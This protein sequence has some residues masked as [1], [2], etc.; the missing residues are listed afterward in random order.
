MSRLIAS[1][2]LLVV[3]T[4]GCVAGD[5]APETFGAASEDGELLAAR[6]R[7]AQLARIFQ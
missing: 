5:S 1:A 3:V 4:S 6:D 2:L 7:I